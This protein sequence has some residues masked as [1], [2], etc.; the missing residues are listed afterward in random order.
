MTPRRP[1]P[2]ARALLLALAIAGAGSLTATLPTAAELPAR[3]SVD[4][5]EVVAK[6]TRHLWD[7]VPG[8]PPKKHDGA[9]AVVR[10]EEFRA[11]TL[12]R[13]GLKDALEEAPVE[14]T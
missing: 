2:R 4:G 1:A 10:P 9:K 7:R 8:T 3:Q 5:P 12:E 6:A 11:F 13:R 14:D